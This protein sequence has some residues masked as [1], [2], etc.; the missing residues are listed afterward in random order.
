M[1]TLRVVMLIL[2]LSGCM[3]GRDYVRP[4]VDVP[5]TFRYQEGDAQQVANTQWWKKF[6][7]P[8]LDGL[9]TEA[10]SNNRDLKIA[11]A[12]IEQAAGVLMQ[13][14]SPLFPQ[15]GYSG[16][17]ARERTSE[18][19]DSRIF[20]FIPNPQNSFQAL[21]S[22]SWEIDLWGRIRRLSE[23]AQAELFATEEAR[24]GVILSLVSTVASNYIQLLGLDE[25]LLIA[26]R[27]LA[28]YAESVKVFELRFRY[29]QISQMNLEQARSQY[30]TAAS[31]IP[32]IEAQI[33]QTEIALSILLG[34]NPGPVARGKTIYQL[35]LLPVPAGLPSDLIENRPDIRQAEQQLIA[36]NAQIGAAKA[37]FFPS[38]SLTGAFGY[39][40]PELSDLFHGPARLWSYG[41]SVTGPIFTGG[42]IFGQLRQAEAMG[43]AALL[44]YEQ[45]IQNSFADVEN[46]LI[47]RK[48]L[49]E[50]LEAQGRLVNANK[51][52]VRLAQL[53]YD[54][55]YSP[56]MTV[57]QA[58]QQLFP[59][60]LNYAQS[61]AGLFISLINIYKAMGGG[62]IEEAE[63]SD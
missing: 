29:G 10:L 22:A 1:R 36:A 6:Q 45:T 47:G 4:K 26:K 19:S 42:A 60:E 43:K 39:A 38:I 31:A 25:Q 46:T 21:A 57:L 14:R 55:G 7:D 41:G 51:E 15:A 52:Y 9:I 54:G 61:R 49:V 2:L 50:Q 44:N 3:M 37:L 53:Q 18:A 16:T 62:W 48:K 63:V 30:E 32:Q 17:G 13:A 20:S 12:N 33:A 23:S 27:T 11:V 58:Q 35:Q 5:G 40:S 59:S 8:V 28:T 56:Y 34:R 24:Q